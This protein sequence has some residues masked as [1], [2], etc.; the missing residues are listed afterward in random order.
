MPP[1]KDAPRP[2]NRPPAPKKAARRLF[3]QSRLQADVP[4]T[5]AAPSAAGCRSE[6]ERRAR[7][8]DASHNMPFSDAPALPTSKSGPPPPSWNNAMGT[9]MVVKGLARIMPAGPW[10]TRSERRG[11]PCHP[12]VRNR[13]DRLSEQ[14]FIVGD[15]R[16]RA[17]CATLRVTAE[18]R[19]AASLDC[20]HHAALQEAQMILRDGAPCSPEA[21][22]HIPHV[23]SWAR[24]DAGSGHGLSLRSRCA[25]GLCT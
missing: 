24:H 2:L 18:R 16:V 17:V 10:D 21:A 13:R 23:P 6:I 7:P 20:G 22:E 15:P 12:A 25:N 14:G 4:A 5:T 1:N 19:C 3:Q 9:W 11:G 8:E